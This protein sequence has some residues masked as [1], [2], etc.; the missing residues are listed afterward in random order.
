MKKGFYLGG[1]IAW[2]R[3]EY[4]HVFISLLLTI[5][6]GIYVSAQYQVSTCEQLGLRPITPESRDTATGEIYP[7]EDLLQI[8][9]ER[10]EEGIG[11][12]GCWVHHHPNG[13]DYVV[14][15][16]SWDSIPNLYRREMIKDAMDAI[17]D[18]RI[19]YSD[20]GK[21]DNQLYYILDDRR[22]DDS[23]HAFL[24]VDKQCWMGS[25]VHTLMGAD[26]NERK[27]IFAHEIGHCFVMENVSHLQKKYALNAWFDE[28]TS[29]FLASELYDKGDW[30]FRFSR[31]FDFDKSFRQ[32][33]NAYPLILYYV[34]EYGK[35]SLV[36][37]LNKLTNSY[38]ILERYEIMRGI[39]FDQLFHNFLYDFTHD[40]IKDSGNSISIPRAGYKIHPPIELNPAETS[41]VL[42]ALGGGRLEMLELLI[43]AGFNATIRPASGT[44]KTL[45]QSLLKENTDDIRNWDSEITLPGNCMRETSVLVQISHLY[46][47]K[48]R[49]LK[50]NYELEAKTDCCSEIEGSLDGCLI[51]R[52]DVDLST[53]SN[54]LSMDISGSLQVTFERS[55]VGQVTSTFN[56]RLDS[57]ENGDYQ[58]HKG[59]ISACVVPEAD[60]GMFSAFRLQGV[61]LG[62]GNI[63]QEYHEYSGETHDI[64]ADVVDGLSV[65]PYN[66]TSCGPEMVTMLYVVILNRMQ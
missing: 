23:G 49:N 37:F 65:I 4:R 24:L 25:G 7:G 61:T 27:Y 62:E 34:R 15:P 33:Y 31:K 35:E 1:F 36:P 55:P 44:H 51:D 45:F 17:T 64:S 11:G 52:W 16:Y 8:Y 54:I 19:F 21:L 58:E 60:G 32:K 47:E 22:Y 63:H 56:L 13:K 48:L 20:Y 50:I 38:R 66:Y 5:L 41:V 29:E 30:E 42:P 39:G 53:L 6:S 3:H 18:A 43:P 57:R 10:N 28:S 9:Y 59:T 40:I 46:V 12:L 26:S 2:N 14:T